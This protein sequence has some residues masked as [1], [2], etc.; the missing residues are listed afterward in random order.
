MFALGWCVYFSLLQYLCVFTLAKGWRYSLPQKYSQITTFL[1][2]V[3]RPFFTQLQEA[4]IP[5]SSHLSTNISCC[6]RTYKVWP[7]LNS[8]RVL[9][10]NCSPHV[11]IVSATVTA[12]H[13]SKMS[14]STGKNGSSGAM[15]WISSAFQFATDRNDFRRWA[16][17][18]KVMRKMS[19]KPFVVSLVANVSSSCDGGN[20]PCLFRCLEKSDSLLVSFFFFTWLLQYCI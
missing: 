2:L 14:G 19:T 3:P 8:V 17:K 5:G 11:S 16:V 4:T 13:V 15:E 20:C 7:L 6:V 9:H 18:D 12:P 1:E 10:V